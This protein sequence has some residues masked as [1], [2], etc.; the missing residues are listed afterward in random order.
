MYTGRLSNQQ[1]L[2]LKHESLTSK[3][4]FRTNNNQH[5]PCCK[6]K[7]KKHSQ[8]EQAATQQRYKA[9]AWKFDTSTRLISQ[10]NNSSSTEHLADFVFYLQASPLKKRQG[11]VALCVRTRTYSVLGK[12]LRQRICSGKTCC[13]WYTLAKNSLNWLLEIPPLK[14]K[15]FAGFFNFQS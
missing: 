7:I 11:C 3:L 9:A 6:N 14:I 15:M 12:F 4:V 8:S 1:G 2:Q 5:T 10:Q 13:Y